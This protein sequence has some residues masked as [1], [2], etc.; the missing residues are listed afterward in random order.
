MILILGRAIL[1]YRT[2]TGDYEK[3][4]G[5]TAMFSQN[6]QS[7]LPEFNMNKNMTVEDDDNVDIKEEW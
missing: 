2:E 4:K 7:I 3:W 5:T 1:D 6:V